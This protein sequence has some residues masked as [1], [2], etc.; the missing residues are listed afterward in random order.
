MS[1][2]WVVVEKTILIM[3]DGQTCA[4]LRAKRSRSSCSFCFRSKASSSA[5]AS[6]MFAMSIDPSLLLAC[7]DSGGD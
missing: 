3:I 7:Q 4:F 6:L 2:V 5:R 1:G